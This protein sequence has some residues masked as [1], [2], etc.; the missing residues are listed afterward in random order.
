MRVC[1]CHSCGESLRL[2]PAKFGRANCETRPRT[3]T[4]ADY[5]RLCANSFALRLLPNVA[6]GRSSCC[7]APDM[8]QNKATCDNGRTVRSMPPG[9][10][11]NGVDSFC[12]RGPKLSAASGLKDG[13]PRRGFLCAC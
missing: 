3:E 1:V 12:T 7:R 2:R 6:K 9:I 5:R 10:L 13:R 11:A 4:L 8:Q